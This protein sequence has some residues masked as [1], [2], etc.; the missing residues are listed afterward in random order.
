MKIIKRILIGLLALI[1]LV[2]GSAIV[3]PII[4]ED[5]IVAMVKEQANKKLNAEVD[6][7]DYDLSLISTFPDFGLSIED[8]E[9]KNKKPF[10]GTTL[11]DIG[12]ISLVVDL[13]SVIN[14]DTYKIKSVALKKPRIHVIVNPDGTANYNIMKA[15]P[16][17]AAPQKEKAPADTAGGT[18]LQFALQEYSISDAH[19]IYNDASLSLFTEATGLDHSGSG[20]FT[21]SKF[22]LETR[23]SIDTFDLNYGGVDYADKVNVGLDA[24]LGMD[25]E[26]MKFTFKENELSL[27]ELVLGF[28]G[29]FAMPEEGF[30]MDLSY[31]TKKTRFRTLLSMIPA[32]YSQSFSNI[33]T[34]GELA[35]NGHI[36]G[37]YSE[38]SYPGFGLDL[39]VEN[40]SFNYPS[41]PKAA[42]NIQMDL[43]VER[44]EGPSLDNTVV[45]LSQ[46]HVELAENPV[47]MHFHLATPMSDPFIDCGVKAQVD[48]ASLRKV[49]PMEDQST[50]GNITADL[51][52]KGHMSTIEKEN[53]EEFDAKGKVILMDM[54]YKSPALAYDV[55]IKKS[56]LNFTPQELSLDKFESTLGKSDL[57]ASGRIDNYIA[58]ALKDEK[59]KGRFELRSDR[60]DLNELMASPEGEKSSGAQEKEAAESESDTAESS[61]G[62]IEVPEKVDVSLNAQ[63]GRVLYGDITMSELAGSIRVK[64]QVASL[65]DV[66]MKVLGGTVK[67]NGTYGTKDPTRPQV[68]FAY[69][70]DNLDIERTAS[71][72]NTVEK[73][74]P[75]AKNCTGS[76]S[77]K[78][79]LSTALDQNMG[80]DYNSMEGKGNLQAKDIHIEGFEPLNELAAKLGIDRLSKQ[81][82]QD[83]KIGFEVR[84]G[85]V[86]VDP[87]TVTMDGSKATISG[88]T[89]FEQKMNYNLDM[90]VPREKLGGKANK[91]MEGLVAKA[92]K[93]GAN[94][95]L[96]ETVPVN[97]QVTGPIQDPKVA[98]D[99]KKGE[100]GGS[101]KDQVKDKA[102]EA[103]DKAKDKAKEKAGEKA[104]EEA[105]KKGD[106]IVKEAKK[107]AERI[108]KEAR[109]AREQI[110]SDAEKRGNKLVNEANNPIAKQAAKESKKEIM[111]EA[112]KEG[113]KKVKEA[114]KKADRIVKEAKKKRQR[115]IDEAKEKAGKGE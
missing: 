107:K 111:K 26:N 93:K 30:D 37:I 46:F 82:I 34:S 79:K 22:T 16:D 48:L 70:I 21:L 104:I 65:K 97:A 33:K 4:F 28:D 49:V 42:K 83:V 7:G 115:L 101:M 8:L 45:D 11:A 12:E 81:N 3:L 27:N 23:T 98:L 64:E 29:Y 73:L 99:L 50:V 77:S 25:L 109:S 18:P 39:T 35:L 69:N 96:G 14:G 114:D 54:L 17:T 102:K 52:M 47:D 60:F 84:D 53:Y 57:K 108:R 9:V 72:V 78:M 13:M 86:H 15:G 38:D 5:E 106:R 62:V 90:E 112:R 95:S 20:D 55:A 31:K 91:M 1:V 2:I 40:G 80:P 74:A 85:K 68:D 32:V 19:L 71:T 89:T 113:D 66:S 59:L 6:F 75:I 103:V 100:E 51:E 56:Y 63:M 92:N 105:R 24:D 67:L 58:Y 61:M 43:E 87:Y 10:E 88:Y 110:I 36:K 41:L 76:F 94:F 44:K